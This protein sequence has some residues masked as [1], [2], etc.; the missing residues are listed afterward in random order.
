MRS[1]TIPQRTH[2]GVED[3]ARAHGIGENKVRHW[4]ATGELRAINVATR[5]GQR[6]RWRIAITDL[7]EF[8]RR[9]SNAAVVEPGPTP[10]RRR[11]DDEVI[12]YFP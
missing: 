4:I 9:R 3:I 10:R 7:E 2:L 8:F 5:P 6:P 1:Q 11:E 12:S